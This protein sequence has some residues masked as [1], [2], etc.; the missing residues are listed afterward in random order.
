MRSCS[1]AGAGL[2][3]APTPSVP[4]E[5]LLLQ[6]APENQL[7]PETLS[8]GYRVSYEAL[9]ITD[10]GELE[11]SLCQQAEQWAPANLLAYRKV[12]CPAVAPDLG[13]RPP[14]RQSVRLL[15]V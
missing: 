1:S 8:N 11:L 5:P 7:T 14:M 4:D 3:S 15:L 6:G 12:G 9:G 2:R 13:S 10:K